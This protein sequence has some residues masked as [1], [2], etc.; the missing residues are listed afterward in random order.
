MWITMTQTYVG[1]LGLFAAGLKY[2]LPDSTIK[3]LP[4]GSYH[5]IPAPWD[6]QKQTQSGQ[7]KMLKGKY[8]KK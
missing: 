5:K 7:N 4:G 1:P 6:A 3:Q 8:R 2:D